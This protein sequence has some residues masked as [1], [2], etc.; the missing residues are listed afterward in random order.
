[1]CDVARPVLSVFCVID[2]YKYACVASQEKTRNITNG[3]RGSRT[4][5]IVTQEFLPLQLSVN[6]LSLTLSLGSSQSCVIVEAC[7]HFLLAALRPWL[8]SFDFG[9]VCVLLCA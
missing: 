3:G 2:S 7:R 6:S 4:P 8:S 9:Y 5:F 1:M